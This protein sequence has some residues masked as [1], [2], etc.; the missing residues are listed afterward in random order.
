MSAEGLGDELLSG[1]K[2]E[3]L[4]EVRNLLDDEGPLY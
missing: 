1:V 3:R 2:E 4:D